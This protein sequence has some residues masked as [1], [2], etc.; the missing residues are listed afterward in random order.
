MMN[1]LFI[2]LDIP[3][4]V[5][6]TVISIRNDIYGKDSNVRW[7]PRS[8]LHITLKFLGDVDSS[9]IKLISK[10]TADIV[11]SFE[12]LELSLDRFGIFYRDGRAKILWLGLHQNE[13]LNKIYKELNSAFTDIGINEEKRKFRSH[14][15][16]LRIKGRENIKRIEKFKS[17]DLHEINFSADTISLYKSK[18]EPSGSI[19][20][21]IQSFKL[22]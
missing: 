13:R 11:S 19:Y 20:S 15:T 2:A 12:K 16:L 5:L 17:F 9:L 1:R 18:L 4:E 10:R 3:E 8:K 14:I 21:K 22:T 6:N 7:E